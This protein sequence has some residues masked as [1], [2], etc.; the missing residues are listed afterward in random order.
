MRSFLS[1]RTWPSLVENGFLLKILSRSPSLTNVNMKFLLPPLQVWNTICHQHKGHKDDAFFWSIIHKTS[2][3]IN[4][5]DIFQWR[6]T[7]I[8]PIVARRQWNR[9]STI[10][11]ITCWLSMFDTMHN[12]IWQ[13]FAKRGSPC[14]H[15]VFLN[16]AMPFRSTS[17]HF[18]ET[19]QSYMVFL[20][21][22]PPHG[23]ASINIMIRSLM[24]FTSQWNET[25]KLKHNSLCGTI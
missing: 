6:S 21:E 16:V 9:W 18:I 5:V 24:L 2:A 11:L 13:F 20:K 12:I 22:R 17:Y 19:Y 15:E 8:V 25:T 23:L 4:G 14:S 10:L 3:V 1:W 7:R